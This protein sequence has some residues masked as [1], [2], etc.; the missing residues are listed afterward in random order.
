MTIT[1]SDDD[2]SVIAPFTNGK[3][4]GT[5]TNG[6]KIIQDV[7][8]YDES[9]TICF[10]DSVV[11]DTQYRGLIGLK[12]SNGNGDQCVVYDTVPDFCGASSGGFDDEDTASDDTDGI[13]Q[14]YVFLPQCFF[15]L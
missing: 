15:T 1:S 2:Q 13:L 6:I 7:D 3:F 4:D 12:D 10:D 14:Y 9:F 5:Y 8:Y 11:G